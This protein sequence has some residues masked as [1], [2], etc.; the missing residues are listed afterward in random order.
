[1]NQS[2]W[3]YNTLRKIRNCALADLSGSTN[4]ET[5]WNFG[6][7]LGLCSILHIHIT[8]DLYYWPNIDF[9]GAGVAQSVLWRTTSWT[10]GVLFP[11][12]ATA[13]R[14]VPKRSKPPVQLLPWVLSSKDS[15]L[16][17]E[18]NHSPPCSGK[19]KNS[20][21]IILKLVFKTL[22]LSVKWINQANISTPP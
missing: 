19:V 8:T 22:S 1:M 11:A 13:C 4:I 5:W 2:L 6:S 12:E 10:A 3:N 20:R 14:P 18:A 16:V 7:L 9:R 15:E 17:R 21:T